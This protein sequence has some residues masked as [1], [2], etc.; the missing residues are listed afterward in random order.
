MGK[1]YTTNIDHC[2]RE[3]FGGAVNTPL[4]DVSTIDV[5]WPESCLNFPIAWRIISPMPPDD[6]PFFTSVGGRWDDVAAIAAFAMFRRPPSG[7]IAVF[8]SDDGPANGRFV[9]TVADRTADSNWLTAVSTSAQPQ[10]FDASRRPVD[11]TGA[12]RVLSTTTRMANANAP[13]KNRITRLA[14]ASSFCEETRQTIVTYSTYVAKILDNCH[15]LTSPVTKVSDALQ[16]DNWILL[17]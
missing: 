9:T 4:A 14:C 12:A 2:T 3:W 15:V 6:L 7:L 13:A 5:R 1:K 10:P 8:C 17:S 16:V 11:E